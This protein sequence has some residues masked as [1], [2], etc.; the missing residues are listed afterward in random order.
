[1]WKTI[2]ATGAKANKPVFILNNKSFT[3]VKDES[4]VCRRYDSLL[5]ELKS[6]GLAI[7]DNTN[8]RTYTFNERLDF[9]DPHQ[10]D[11]ARTILFKMGIDEATIKS[12]TKSS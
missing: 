3:V 11:V 12:F 4:V 10:L 5:V 9:S 2:R 1:M 7:T 6:N 8:G